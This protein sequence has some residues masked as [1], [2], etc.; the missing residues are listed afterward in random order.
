MK[1]KE[2]K[3]EKLRLSLIELLISK[4]FDENSIESIKREVLELDDRNL[5]IL[6]AY[7]FDQW[8][9]DHISRVKDNDNS[10]EDIDKHFKLAL[11]YSEES[12]Q[13]HPTYDI[14]YFNWGWRM[15]AYA[16]RKKG[17]DK[18]ELVLEEIN[19]YEIA[20]SLNENNERT[21]HNWGSS[22]RR[23]A[24]TKEV[25]QKINYLKEAAEKLE[26]SVSIDFR[27][28]KVWNNLGLVYSDLGDSST[29]ESDYWRRKSITCY[30]TLVKLYPYK[31][32][33]YDNWGIVLKELALNS[34]G[35]E[36][37]QLF[38][39]AI[40]KHL[41]AIENGSDTYNL[42]CTYAVQGDGHN[43]FI[44]LKK[45]LEVDYVQFHEVLEDSDWEAYKENESFKDLSRTNKV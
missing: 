30:S 11:K 1:N 31:Q 2:T 24:L 10:T 41:K 29:S 38:A 16:E 5:K 20:A 22:L 39:Q 42:A 34:K 28:D 18:E 40:E 44:H 14:Y 43:A 25:N 23:L 33:A 4:E 15:G 37:E 45:A 9:T 21:Y 17:I 3:I 36:R 7:L 12:L 27:Q 35:A 8:A 19:K 13:F 32:S 26:K 6:L